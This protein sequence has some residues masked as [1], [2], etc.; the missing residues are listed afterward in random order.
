MP[1]IE[2]RNCAAAT[3]EIEQAVSEARPPGRNKHLMEFIS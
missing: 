2:N 1:D 3:K